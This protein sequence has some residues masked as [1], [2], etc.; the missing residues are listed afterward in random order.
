MRRL[1]IIIIIKIIKLLLQSCSIGGDVLNVTVIL[2][3]LLK[4][5]EYYQRILSGD[6]LVL[7]VTVK[8]CNC[9]HYFSIWHFD[10]QPL[11]LLLLCA[12]HLP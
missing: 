8:E 7:T 10:T 2:A 4:L 9:Y 6:C 5:E 12:L 1:I 3:V 11:Y